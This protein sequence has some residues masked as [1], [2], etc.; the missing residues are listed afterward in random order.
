MSNFIPAPN[1][2]S[3]CPNPQ[4]TYVVSAL[5]GCTPTHPNSQM[6]NCAPPQ[7]TTPG[8]TT[9]FI[10]NINN[11]LN[12]FGC[13]FLYKRTNI[14]R[15]KLRLLQNNIAP[16]SPLGQLLE[17]MLISIMNTGSI[18]G[19]TTTGTGGP[20]PPP[21]SPPNP[22]Y[23][24]NSGSAVANTNYA[25]FGGWSNLNSVGTSLP[26]MNQGLSTIGVASGGTPPPSVAQQA[27]AIM[28]TPIQ[29]AGTVGRNPNWQQ[30]LENRIQWM[31]NLALQNCTGGPTPPPPPPPTPPSTMV[32]CSTCSGG[33]PQSNMFPNSCPPGW[34]SG[35][36][37]PCMG[38]GLGGGMGTGG[39]SSPPNF[40]TGG[41]VVNNGFTSY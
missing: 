4:G 34:S 19:G 29:P 12:Q 6:P 35:N 5:G 25:S 21:P 2:W 3:N 40:G 7:P 28:N 16:N 32:V 13:T 37:N 22:N 27:L 26:P 14:Q 39:P 15:A 38:T 30:M 41:G 1:C 17:T 31:N 20:T 8:L 18:A 24:M 11:G 9:N 33:L 23:P 10:N 36:S